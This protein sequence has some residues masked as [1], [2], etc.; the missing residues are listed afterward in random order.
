M[1][2]QHM[3][4][5]ITS[6]F[7]FGAVY[8]GMAI[9]LVSFSTLQARLRQP[10]CCRTFLNMQTNADKAFPGFAWRVARLPK[11]LELRHAERLCPEPREGE[12]R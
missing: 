8:Q 12:I 4:Q 9:L 7:G 11:A 1:R 3:L 2:V 5:V 10:L 6:P